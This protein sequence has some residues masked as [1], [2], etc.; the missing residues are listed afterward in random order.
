VTVERT[1]SVGDR[2]PAVT[3]LMPVRNAARWL[4]DALDSVRTQTLGD[5]ELVAVDDGSDDASRS[6]LDRHRDRD[7]RI[8]VVAGEPDD[9]G[10]VA[11]LNLGLGAARAPLLARMD[12]DDVMHA[13]RLELQRRALES[14]P[15]L[16]AVS[17]RV[18][19]FPDAN[20]GEGMRRYLA[21]QNELTGPDELA[22]DRF[23]EMP[24]L[25]P[26][27]MMRTDVMRERLGGWRDAGWAE[28]WDL[29]LRAFAGGLRVARVPHELLYW[30][31]H[32]EQATRVDPRYSAE[33]FMQAR[34]HFLAAALAG[35]RRPLWILGA[36]PVGKK[37]GK[38]LQRELAA[39]KA[40]VALAGFVDVDPK[41]IGGVVHDGR[42]RWPVISMAELAALRP[43]PFAI[44]AVGQRG[45]RDRV[46]GALAGAGWREGDDFLVAA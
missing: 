30:R 36:G 29:F 4:D 38:S 13:E 3:V 31:V 41:K 11:A 37:L 34:A 14:D 46:R 16:F 43:R 24:L 5:W 15:S 1:R 2:A 33:R 7:A 12:A 8:H 21:W 25:H 19:A 40:P 39:A 28:D 32:D 20:V 6:I 9:A 27:V 22:R 35:A 26:S 45:G 10:I 18:G 42:H 17:C 44:A 23:V